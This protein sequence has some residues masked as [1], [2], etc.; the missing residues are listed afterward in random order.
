MRYKLLLVLATISLLVLVIPFASSNADDTSVAPNYFIQGY[1][2][3]IGKMPMAGVTVSITDSTGLAFQNETDENGFFSVGVA[4]NTGLQIS[5]TT[6]GYTAITCPNTSSLQGSDYLALNLAKASY[7]T[8]THT[9][10]ITGSIADMQ[11]AIM[12]ASNGV[13]KGQVS[14][15]TTSIKDANVTLKPAVDTPASGGGGYTAQTDSNGYYEITCPT[16]TYNLTVSRQG[17]NQSD[18]IPVKVTGSP[19]TV[20][21]L[22]VKSELKKHLGLDNAHVLMLVGVVVGIMLAVAAWFLSRRMNGPHRLE[23]IDDSEDEDK[24]VRYP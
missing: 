19:S 21:V 13:I 15:G 5:F 14:F 4:S 18:T 9:Y 24:D 2:A 7:N 10:T 23:I 8:S 11:C 22:M 12:V 16:G 20:N 17:F 3:D 1:V 6:F